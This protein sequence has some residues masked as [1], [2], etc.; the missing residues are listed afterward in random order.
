MLQG[1][2][3]PRPKKHYRRERISLRM[4]SSIV[5]AFNQATEEPLRD[6]PAFGRRAEIVEGL[7]RDWLIANGHQHLLSEALKKEQL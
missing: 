5:E 6:K 3:M 7:L 1:G 2:A 4:R